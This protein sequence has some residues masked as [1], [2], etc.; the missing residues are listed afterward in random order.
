MRLYYLQNKLEMTLENR[1]MIEYLSSLMKLDFDAAK[2][3]EAAI[4]KIG[5]AQINGRMQNFLDDHMRHVEN[6]SDIIARLGGTPP[7]QSSGIRGLFLSGATSLQGLTGTGGALKALQ[8]EEKLINKTYN[9]AVHQGFPY[10]IRKT[11]DANFRDEQL[12]I[13]YINSTLENKSWKE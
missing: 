6:L 9:D 13:E 7:E 12:H 11:L 5:D 4:Q 1:E 3:Y 2:T 10:E 8:S